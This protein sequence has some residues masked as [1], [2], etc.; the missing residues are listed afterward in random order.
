VFLHH[1]QN[2]RRD[3]VDIAQPINDTKPICVV[4]GQ[5]QKANTHL[6]LKRYAKIFEPFFDGVS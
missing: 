2:I 4:L 5:V 6:F 3:N 1:V